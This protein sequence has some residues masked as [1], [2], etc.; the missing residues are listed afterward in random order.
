VIFLFLAAAAGGHGIEPS[1]DDISFVSVEG[2]PVA[3][4]DCPLDLLLAAEYAAEVLGVPERLASTIAIHESRCDEKA[5][6]ALGEVGV[7]QI[8]PELWL[9]DLCRAGIACSEAELW[10][11]TTTVE[12][13]VWILSRFPGSAWSRAK[14]YNGSA[15]YADAIRRKM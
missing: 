10:D 7:M 12:A 9:G 2:Y 4:T 11:A 6:G 3:K 5:L 1:R 14:R 13:G 8:R 15:A